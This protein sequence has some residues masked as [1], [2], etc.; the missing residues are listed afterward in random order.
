MPRALTHFDA[1]VR[2]IAEDDPGA[3]LGQYNE[4]NKQVRRLAEHPKLGRPSRRRAGARRLSITGT[5]FVITYRIRPRAK[6]IEITRFEH[7]R[8]RRVA[9]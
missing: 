5:P 3:A 8:Q 4:I 2:R 1:A 9:D 6:R 7:T